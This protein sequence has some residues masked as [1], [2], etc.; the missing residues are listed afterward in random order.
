VSERRSAFD[1]LADLLVYAPLGLAL[2]L[3]EDLPELAAKGRAGVEPRLGTARLVGQF[4]VAEGRRR[5]WRG[6]GPAPQRP[7]GTQPDQP[8]RSAAVDHHPGAPGEGTPGAGL[9]PS[10]GG[11][12][13]GGAASAPRS[14]AAS[15]KGPAPGHPE[16]PSPAGL[17]IPGYDSLS[18]SQVV[19]RL[20]GLSSAELAA[21][22]EYEAATRGR[23]TILARVHQL[24][25]R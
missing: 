12:A 20:D 24:Q 18:A 25:D 19:Q 21:V 13:G 9:P 5:L 10:S 4:A 16:A 1:A 23:R 7:A 2:T 3:A 6:T 11:S 22:G 15:G 14:T 17:A 8:G